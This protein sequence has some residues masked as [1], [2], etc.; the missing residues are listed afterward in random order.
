MGKIRNYLLSETNKLIEKRFS[1]LEQK[2]NNLEL[3]T[4]KDQVFNYQV[5]GHIPGL[6]FIKSNELEYF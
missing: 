5:E 4:P 1:S 6:L 2:L 3:N